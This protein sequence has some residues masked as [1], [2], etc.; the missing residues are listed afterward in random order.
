MVIFGPGE[1]ILR[2]GDPGDSLYVVRSGKVVVQI[3]VHGVARELATLT[4]GQFFGEMSLMTGE[5]R[6]ATV[7]AKS[8]DHFGND[9]G[10]LIFFGVDGTT[11]HIVVAGSPG[12]TIAF[13]FSATLP[14][15]LACFVPLRRALSV[16]PTTALKYE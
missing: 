8:D 14:A 1:I 11:Y 4:T 7:V 5:S 16:D 13:A 2:Q 10:K 6:T 3:E 12:G 9:A 15:F